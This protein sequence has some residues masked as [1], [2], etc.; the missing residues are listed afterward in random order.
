[1]GDS[2]SQSNQ[3]Y[4]D[5]DSEFKKKNNSFESVKLIQSIDIEKHCQFNSIVW[6]FCTE[7]MTLDLT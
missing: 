5:S 4:L 6:I 7:F 2:M 1:M 3:Q